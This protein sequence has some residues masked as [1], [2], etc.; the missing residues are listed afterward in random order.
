MTIGVRVPATRGGGARDARDFLKGPLANLSL[1]VS[2]D[3]ASAGYAFTA[4]AP[5]LHTTA[6]DDAPPPATTTAARRRAR[7]A[8]RRALGRGAP[9]GRARP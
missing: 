4:V 1:R 8:A 6:G 3:N 5:R 9:R 7:G 2:Y